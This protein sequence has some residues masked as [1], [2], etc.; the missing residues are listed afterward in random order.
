MLG[1]L[2]AHELAVLP[3]SFVHSAG[4]VYELAI[5][6]SLAVE[7]IANIVVTIGVNE[8]TEATVNVIFELAFIDDVVD[9]LADACYLSV[10]T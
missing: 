5:A 10:G 8:P 6:R 3:L 7:P 2:V 9:F 4:L 1:S